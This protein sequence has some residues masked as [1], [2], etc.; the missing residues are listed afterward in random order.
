MR[1]R[2]YLILIVAAVVLP[3]TAL[4]AYS[5]QQNFEHTKKDAHTLLK[6]ES[7]ILATNV[8]TQLGNLRHRLDYLASLSTSA[9]LDPEHCDPGLKHLLAMHQ[10]Y[11]NIVTTDL[12][13]ALICS[14]LPFAPGKPPSAATRPW[15]QHLLKEQ[16]FSVGEPFFGPIVGKQVLIV[17]QPLRASDLPEGRMLGSIAV[18]IGITAF[19]PM[20]PTEHLPQ[21]SLYGFMNDD[22]ALIWRNMNADEIGSHLQ[23][24]AS[25]RVLQVRNGMFEATATDGIRRDY[26]V[27]SLPEFGLLAFVAI[28]SEG[29]HTAALHDAMRII[30]FSVGLLIVLLA[31]VAR[32]AQRI[33]RPL[34]ALSRTAQAIQVGNFSVRANVTGLREITTLATTFNAMVDARQQAEELLQQQTDQLRAAKYLLDERI[35]E[36]ACLYD[37]SS[38]C[39]RNDL[40]I[41]TLLGA[42]VARL[43]AAMRFP[44][45]A[46]AAITCGSRH[47]GER[48]DGLHLCAEF[49]GRNSEAATICVIYAK[50][51]PN[52]AGQPFLAEERSM[53]EAIA[54]RIEASVKRG[55]SL[56]TEAAS[57]AWRLAILDKAPLAI[58]LVDAETLRFVEAN[59]ASC[60]MLGYSRD[61]MLTMRVTD[62]Q[63]QLSPEELTIFAHDL[64]TSGRAELD[65]LHRCKDGSLIDVHLNVHVIRQKGRDYFVSAWRDITAEKDA[66]TR[67]RMLSLAVEQSP[68]TVLITNLAADTIYVNDAF[69]RITG[70]SREEILGRNPR[71]LKSGKTPATTY[72]AMWHALTAGKTWTGELI[73]RAKDGSEQIHATTIAPIRGEDGKVCQYVAV[74]ENVTEQR[75]IED[76]L[77]KLSLAVDQSPESIVITNLDANIEYVNQAFIQNTV[78]TWDEAIGANPRLLQSGKTP[79]ATYQDMWATL[80]QGK[81]W[82]G[83]LYNTR[84]NGSEYVEHAIIAPVRQADG[85]VTHYLAIKEDVTEKKRMSDELDAYRNSLEQQVVQR[86]TELTAAIQ[87]QNALFDSAGAGIV[88]I[89]DRR[90]VR[91]NH[92]MD[93]LLGYAYGEQIGQSAR[94]WY[95]DE[96]SYALVGNEGY[97]AVRQGDT[98]HRELEMVRKVKRGAINAPAALR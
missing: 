87:E 31:I 17:S 63:G 47:F 66:A 65:N 83:D 45:L 67:I 80:T 94:I 72:D 21:G 74:K 7:E 64:A 22:G 38:L 29:I 27:K 61:E 37:V 33:T 73:N 95:P 62:I 40:D 44:D 16:R 35:K 48:A 9:L 54:A 97:A 53:L 23:D 68:N 84:K 19:D 55:E 8:R 82:R 12:S 78:Y 76:R 86:T 42:I 32:V 18:T 57:R 51:L 20:F 88:L 14:A 69:S 13:G 41:D 92:R 4:L 26:A 96:E 10:E 50:P 24:E 28:P 77:R 5:I 79:L 52:D 49:T 1:I 39:E 90:I 85:K 89:K 34:N 93:E 60:H 15:F 70:Y 59:D 11:A 36:L 75:R 25:K 71:M 98:D 56:A 2:S 3:L 81:P 58:E 30:S 6:I 91:C 43:P 46:V